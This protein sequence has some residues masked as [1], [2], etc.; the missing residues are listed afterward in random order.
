MAI[1]IPLTHVAFLSAALFFDAYFFHFTILALII[2]DVLLYLYLPHGTHIKTLLRIAGLPFI[3][4]LTTAA[5]LFFSN[6]TALSVFL[7]IALFV[8]QI[9]YFIIQKNTDVEQVKNKVVSQISVFICFAS[10]FSLS[11]FFYSLIYFLDLQVWYLILP[12]LCIV[13]VLQESLF[14]SLEMDQYL[15]ILA[16]LVS[17]VVIMEVLYAIS[18]LPLE[19]LSLAGIVSLLYMLYVDIF[20]CS[21]HNEISRKRIFFSSV[22]AIFML[23]L[24]FTLVRW[25]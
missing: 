24:L 3:Y 23:V 2:S 10:F 18:W 21:L 19:Y 9:I 1:L 22:V 15:R 4:F 25:R 16:Q 20:L 14:A 17:A 11:I 7:L 6:S 5:A 8:L 13:Y 12:F